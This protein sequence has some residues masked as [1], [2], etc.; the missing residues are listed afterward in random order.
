MN[1]CVEKKIKEKTIIKEREITFCKINTF[2]PFIIT[3]EKKC[4]YT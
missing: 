4:I 2:F 1:K 3:F